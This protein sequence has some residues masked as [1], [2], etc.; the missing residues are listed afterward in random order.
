M[1]PEEDKCVVCGK[2]LGDD[3]I[4]LTEERDERG[5]MRVYVVDTDLCRGCL[6]NQLSGV[7]GSSGE[8]TASA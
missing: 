5:R 3:D 2:S 4:I 6:D 8:G 1:L 7:L